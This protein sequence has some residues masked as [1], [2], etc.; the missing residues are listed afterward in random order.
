MT[1]IEIKNL[2]NEISHPVNA[3]PLDLNGSVEGITSEGKTLKF[4][5]VLPG[6]SH[7]QKREL[8]SVIE[9][10][11]LAQDIEAFVSII[12]RPVAELSRSNATPPPHAGKPV[13]DL[14]N[15]EAFNHMRSIVAVHSAKGGV[16]KSTVS[17]GLAQAFARKGLKVAIIDLDI[18]GPSVPRIMGT[19]GEIQVY[20]EQFIPMEKDGIYTI[21][22]GNLVDSSAPI[23][24]RAP[25]VNG[26]IRQIF[27]NTLWDE[28]FDVCVIDMPPGTGDIAITVGQ[29]IPLSG[30]VAVSTP[31]AVAMED[32]AKGIGMFRKMHVP[33]L[34]LVRNMSMLVCPDCKKTMPI[35]PKSEEFDEF[36]KENSVE[37]LCELPLDPKITGLADKGTLNKVDLTS[38]WAQEITKAAEIIA[39]RLILT[40]N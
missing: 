6:L 38:I 37:V 28:V 4:R 25:I 1:E 23:V 21:S 14:I 31:Q 40:K 18:Y 29:S 36:L 15:K 22:V 7:E 8:R 35:Y 12:D 26:V 5:L 20:D 32:T 16:G 19:E 30:V 9:A 2:L 24:W 10:K 27:E 39:S 11:F 3:T 13:E 17:V 34:G 33:V